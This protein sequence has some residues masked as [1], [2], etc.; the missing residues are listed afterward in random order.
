MGM[1][2]KTAKQLLGDKYPRVVEQPKMLEKRPAPAAKN[3]VGGMNKTEEAYARRLNAQM[4]SGEIISWRYE[5]ISFRLAYRCQYLPDFLVVTRDELQIHEVKGGFVREDAWIKW[6]MA[7]E[8]NP[9][10][11]FYLCMYSG[12]RWKIQEYKK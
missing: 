1:P 7:A 4:L 11:R 3:C 8:Q 6:K 12:G 5:P 9:E 2:E 10:F